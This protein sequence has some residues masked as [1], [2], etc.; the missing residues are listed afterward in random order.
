MNVEELDK[1][2]W[3]NT[4]VVTT[5]I[6]FLGFLIVRS[7][8]IRI[9]KKWS[10]KD[11]D[12]RRKRVVALKNAL[13]VVF[14]LG[15]FFIW[16][17]EVRAFALSLVAV[18]AAFVIATKEII[19]CLMG[20]V[21]KASTK[22]FEVG[23]RIEVADFRGEVTDHNFLVTILFEIGPGPKTNQFT[24][25]VLK[26]PNSLFLSQSVF[27]EPHGNHYNLAV[28]K[29]PLERGEDVK[30]DEQ[31]LLRVAKSV[32]EPY[33]QKA[34]KHIRAI[35]KREGVETPTLEP[36]VLYDLV[37]KNTVEYHVRMPVPFDKKSILEKSLVEN[38]FEE[39]KK[40][41][42]KESQ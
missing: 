18:A 31:L 21:L 2:D 5:V 8:L 38:F 30:T 27:V 4:N 34:D 15:I 41:I 36:R 23:D 19:L 1:V 16:G 22:L 24:G 35:C 11:A 17:S 40:I 10:F 20:G 37:D 6:F 42:P 29:I 26:I 28:F 7:L 13:F 12:E 3:T 32:C 9:V 33:Y 14:L 25:R 39:R